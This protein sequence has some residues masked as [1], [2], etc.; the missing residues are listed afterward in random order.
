MYPDTG[1]GHGAFSF[2]GTIKDGMAL[3]FLMNLRMRK[4]RY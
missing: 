4:E 1:D 3:T 2:D